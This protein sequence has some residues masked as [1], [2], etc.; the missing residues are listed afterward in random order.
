MSRSGLLWDIG[1]LVAI[2]APDSM[3]ATVRVCWRGNEAAFSERALCQNA[4][5]LTAL[6]GTRNIDQDWQRAVDDEAL[7]AG[8]S[9]GTAEEWAFVQFAQLLLAHRQLNVVAAAGA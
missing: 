7:P 6:F 1:C 5:W 4:E 3:G 8:I 2:Y 9:V